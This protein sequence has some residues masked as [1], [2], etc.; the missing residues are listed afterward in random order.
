MKLLNEQHFKTFKS[1]CEIRLSMTKNQIECE[2]AELQKIKD[3]INNLE[4]QEAVYKEVVE[5]LSK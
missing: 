1:E 2:K 5:A 4:G 3:R